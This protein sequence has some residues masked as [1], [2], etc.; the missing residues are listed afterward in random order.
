M[1]TDLTA[2]MKALLGPPNKSKLTFT[3]ESSAAEG[4]QFNGIEANR[5]H[6]SQV[7]QHFVSYFDF[8]GV[9]TSGLSYT[10]HSYYS[11]AC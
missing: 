6:T 4:E 3:P 9:K 1:T 8:H 10:I 11:H 5:V 2:I 7:L